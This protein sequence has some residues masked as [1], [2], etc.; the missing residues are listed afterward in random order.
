M[1]SPIP[2][3]WQVPQLFRDRMGAHAGR[4][5]CMLA[6]GHLLIV[7]HDVPDPGKRQRRAATLF[8][9]MPDGKWSCSAG[10]PPTIVP[11]QQ[12]VQGYLDAAGQH[13]SLLDAAIGA[14][15]WYA[16]VHSCVPL[17]RSAAN[18]RDALQEARDAV[19]HDR[20][21][22]TVRDLAT[23]A[24]RA[25]ELIQIHAN[26]GL[27]YTTAKRAEEQ[28]RN[29]EHMLASAHRLNLIAAVFL[30]VTAL[31]TLFGMNLHSGLENLGRPWTFWALFAL[32][33]LA[34]LVIKSSLPRPPAPVQAVRAPLALTKPKPKK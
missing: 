33:L 16:L 2:H 26:E 34:G 23:D 22:I 6:D 9:R 24:A 21:L 19:K 18:M 5:R 31:A 3:N 25:F 12:H 20:D 7:L 10:G 4:Q 11:L 14:D 13:E 28:S 27:D 29:A 17:A 1:S 32:S 8:W 30:P 15:D